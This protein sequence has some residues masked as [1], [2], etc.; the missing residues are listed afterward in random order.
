MYDLMN[1]YFP[2]RYKL[3]VHKLHVGV[4]YTRRKYATLM[5]T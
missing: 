1:N 2:I 3:N 5:Y 4:E